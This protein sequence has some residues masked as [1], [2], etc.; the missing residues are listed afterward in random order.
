MSLSYVAY[1]AKRRFGC[2]HPLG[3]VTADILEGDSNARQVQWCRRCGAY[4]F[5]FD[6][7]GL[8]PREGEW[9]IPSRWWD[10]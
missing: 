10:R 9:R 3:S 4:R 8:R 6:P 1:K 7:F 2:Q 5:V